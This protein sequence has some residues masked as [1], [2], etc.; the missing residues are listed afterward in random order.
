[1]LAGKGD[2]TSLRE[3]AERERQAVDELVNAARGLLT[4]EGQELSPAVIE[5]VGETLHAAALD[6]E[7]RQQ[8]RSGTLQRELRH[9]GFG[10]GTGAGNALRLRPPRRPRRPRRRA[11][12]GKSTPKQDKDRPQ[13]ARGSA[14]SRA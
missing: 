6:D 11:A 2:R 9:V 1:M 5:R 14:P 13:R 4:S 3:A 10:A 8:V 7:A 12:K